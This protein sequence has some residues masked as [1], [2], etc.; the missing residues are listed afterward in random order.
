MSNTRKTIEQ[1]TE[2]AAVAQEAARK[3]WNL[4]VLAFEAHLAALPD[5]PHIR[6][7]I[8]ENAFILS[9]SALSGPWSA[10]SQNWEAQKKALSEH[11]RRIAASPGPAVRVLREIA[12]TCTETRMAGA[13]RRYHSDLVSACRDEILALCD[14]AERVFLK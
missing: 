5:N 14:A 11:A 12:G 7:R 13:G 8:G 1:A 10:F 3:A 9:S 6:K 4:A 2:K